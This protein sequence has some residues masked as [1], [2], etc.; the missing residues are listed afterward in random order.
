MALESYP[1][2]F[3]TTVTISRGLG[4]WADS[5]PA[6]AGQSLSASPKENQK[7]ERYDFD[8]TRFLHANRYP[9]CSKTL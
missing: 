2:P 9:L 1:H 7:P 8:L 5:Q 6:P 3:C 4:S